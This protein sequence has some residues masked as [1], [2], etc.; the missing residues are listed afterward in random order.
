[1]PAQSQE[2]LPVQRTKTME[3]DVLYEMTR[4]I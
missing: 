3:P 2:E 1:M 4:K